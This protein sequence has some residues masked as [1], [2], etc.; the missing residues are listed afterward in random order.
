MAAA[1]NAWTHFKDAVVDERHLDDLDGENGVRA[2]RVG[3]GVRLAL[4]A[5]AL[6][7]GEQPHGFL[8]HHQ[9]PSQCCVAAVSRSSVA[10]ERSGGGARTSSV[11]T[12]TLI[13]PVMMPVF[14]LNVNL[15]AGL[16]ESKNRSRGLPQ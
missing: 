2:R 3:V 4:R 10:E 16:V 8:Y 1:G 9:T 6:R 12:R 11:L 5:A 14:M 13:R 7:A 15:L